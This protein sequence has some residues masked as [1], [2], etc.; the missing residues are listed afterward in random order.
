MSFFSKI[1]KSQRYD[2]ETLGHIIVKGLQPLVDEWLETLEEYD[3]TDLVLDFMIDLPTLW[4]LNA[5]I[6]RIVEENETVPNEGEHQFF[7]ARIYGNL[8]KKYIPKDFHV[9]NHIATRREEAIN[10]ISDDKNSD[11]Q[12]YTFMVQMAATQYWRIVTEPIDINSTYNTTP[13]MIEGE[14]KMVAGG[15]RKFLMPDLAKLY[16]S[17][18]N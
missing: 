13:M 7:F 6:V 2:N 12:K 18:I 9:H 4:H 17:S 5:F 1:F 8:F 15:Y 3:R 16:L 14:M 10:G 11:Y